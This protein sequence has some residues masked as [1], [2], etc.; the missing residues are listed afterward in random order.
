MRDTQVIGLG[1]AITAAQTQIIIVEVRDL[2]NSSRNLYF[3]GN[4]QQAQ[5]NLFRA[6]NRWALTGQ[7]ENQEIEHWLRLVYIALN[8]NVE[9]VISPTAPLFPEMSQLLNQAQRNFEEGQ[10]YIN[11]G[12]RDLGMAKFDEARQLTREVRL[13]FPFN[14]DAGLLDL[15]IEQFLDPPAFNAAFT[16]R[17]NTAIAGTRQQSIVAFADLLNLAE[18]NPQYPNMRAII[19]QAE[20]NMGI[21]LPTPDPADIAL[22]RDLTASARRIADANLVAQYEV[23]LTQLDQAIR[24]NPNNTE[25]LQV[26]DRLLPRINLPG[27]IV[28][29]REDELAYNEAER[30]HLAGNN[31]AAYSILQRLMQN[32]QN[33]NV[34]KLARLYDRVRP[35]V[36]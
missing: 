19:I 6:R 13:V 2:I 35:F 27:A 17:L 16:Q 28:L 25:A 3:N 14:Q 36:L 23:A 32:P 29:T 12:Q 22:S 21:R 31:L 1:Q 7:D 11:A 26:R 15:R 8:M 33:R 18:I 5:D 4:F 24:L 9:R 34:E 10:R 30:H 20:V